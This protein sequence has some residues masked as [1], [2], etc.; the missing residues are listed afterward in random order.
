MRIVYVQVGIL[1]FYLM[2]LNILWSASVQASLQNVSIND[3]CVLK[4]CRIRT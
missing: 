1:S 4:A 3:L 2:L